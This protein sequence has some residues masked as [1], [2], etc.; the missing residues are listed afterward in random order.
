MIDKPASEQA[1]GICK[2]HLD[3]DKLKVLNILPS[4]TSVYSQNKI[5]P[6]HYLVRSILNILFEALGSNR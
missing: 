4:N 2:D 3:F 5:S 1:W 6:S